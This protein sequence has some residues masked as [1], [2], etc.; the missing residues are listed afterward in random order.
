MRSGW[1]DPF[2]LDHD[3]KMRVKQEVT[4][5]EQTNSL[6]DSQSSIEGQLEQAEL[7]IRKAQAE[8]AT[9]K[10]VS[11]SHV[12]T[13][14]AALYRRQRLTTD[15]ITYINKQS[16][17]KQELD[18][19]ITRMTALDRKYKESYTNEKVRDCSEQVDLWE[20]LAF[21]IK[22]QEGKVTQLEN[23]QQK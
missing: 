23:A 2:R 6:M 3:A 20:R 12:C 14:P 22:K 18:S 4:F 9:P 7:Q 21:T 13:L 10:E 15:Q 5:L 16:E 1:P 11:H 8:K 17:P 19:I